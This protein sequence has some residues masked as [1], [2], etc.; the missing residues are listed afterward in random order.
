[1]NEKK[2]SEKFEIIM[3]SNEIKRIGLCIS[4]YTDYIYKEKKHID[5]N[6]Q[7]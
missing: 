1:M 6:E 7:N 4:I 3:N 5:E 2:N